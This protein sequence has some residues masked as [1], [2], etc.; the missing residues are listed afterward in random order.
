MA[1]RKF[2]YENVGTVYKNMQNITGD[3]SNAD[4]IAGI[5]HNIDEEFHNRVD[6]CEEAIFGDLGKQLLLDWDN[7][8]SCFPNFVTNFSNWSTLIAQSAGNYA[9]FEQDIKGFNQD[10]PLGVTSKGITSNYIE[11]S[12]YMNFYNTYVD[13]YNDAVNNLLP[14]YDLTGA[15][16]VDTETK[17]N[18]LKSVAWR[19]VEEALA[20][21]SVIGGV[22]GLKSGVDIFRE[23]YSSAKAAAGSTVKAVW[24]ASSKG[25]SQSAALRA[26]KGANGALEKSDDIIKAVTDYVKN[27]GTGD[28]AIE[29]YIMKYA[30]TMS[31]TDVTYEQASQM[32]K[33]WIDSGQ[34]L[35]KVA[36]STYNSGAIPR[37]VDVTATGANSAS[38]TASTIRNS[39]RN[40]VTNTGATLKNAVTHP[41]TTLKT[42]GGTVKNVATNIGS[43]LTHPKDIVSGV[44][45]AFNTI[46]DTSGP[47]L[48]TEAASIGNV[49][50]D[51]NI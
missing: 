25:T 51:N 35:G 48:I 8:S 39:L 9:Q 50:I 20:V 43:H 44:G 45:T 30:K 6:V 27:G 32:M 11:S 34:T 29:A 4:S 26:Y 13:S 2:D 22:K 36:Q 23:L 14:I 37:S 16:Y 3:E 24:S 18:L 47:T 17:K 31:G 5:L 40:T 28:D 1:E 19:A 12:D 15:T 7:T 10:N 42:F 33:Q 46:K 38:S 49:L 41:I 21:V